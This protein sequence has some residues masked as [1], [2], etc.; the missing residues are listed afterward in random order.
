MSLDERIR[1]LTASSPSRSP[2]GSRLARAALPALLTLLPVGRALGADVVTADTLGAGGVVAGDPDAIGSLLSA[3]ALQ[4]LAPRYDVVLGARLAGTD[5]LLLQGLA[6]DSRTGP[7]SLSLAYL[8]H[9]ASPPPDGA[10][11]PGWRLPDEDLENPIQQSAVLV[12]AAAPLLEGRLALGVSTARYADDS[13]YTDPETTWE[14]G[15]GVSG[16]PVGPLTLSLGAH[17]LL[18]LFRDG[19]TD[20]PLTTTAGIGLRSELGGLFGQAELSLH[21]PATSLPFGWRAGGELIL[22][23]GT[24]PLRLGLRHDPDPDTTYLC[25]GIGISAPVATIDYA[26]L[27]DIGPNGGASDQTGALTW[28]SLSIRVLVPDAE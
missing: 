3:P 18:D 12:G 25:A 11:L 21:D 4:A 17:H 14:A 6:R 2:Y 27:R 26:L 10:D 5:D 23:Q 1:L 20:H 7:V 24:L 22:A 9:T 15:L 16:R 28:H 13:A 19:D 8:R